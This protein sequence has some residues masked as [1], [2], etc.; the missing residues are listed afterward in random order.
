MAK[1]KHHVSKD[2]KPPRINSKQTRIWPPS[3]IYRTS[4]TRGSLLLDILRPFCY[5]LGQRKRKI[6]KRK[7]KNRATRLS[8]TP[9]SVPLFRVFI[10]CCAERSSFPNHN[11]TRISSVASVSSPERPWREAQNIRPWVHRGLD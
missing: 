3:S 1:T 6:K 7:K 4:E 2:D 10:F 5:A 8:R 9:R 11:P